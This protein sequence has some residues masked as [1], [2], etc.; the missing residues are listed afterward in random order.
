MNT[1]DLTVDHLFFEMEFNPWTVE[2]ELDW[3]VRRYAYHDEL[4]LPN[5]NQEYSGGISFTHDM[6]V[7]ESLFSP[8]LFGV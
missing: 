7:G 1:F 5:D 2:N 3:F 8:W 6:G 4:R